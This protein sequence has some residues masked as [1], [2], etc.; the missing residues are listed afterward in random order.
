MRIVID[1]QA[2]QGPSRHRGIGRYAMALAQGLARNRGEHEI[3][4]ALNGLLADTIEPIRAALSGLV[5]ETNFLVWTAPGPVA[6]ADPLNDPRR[7]AAELVRE[8][9]LAS[10]SPD[11]VIVSS[12]FEGYGEDIVTSIGSLSSAVPTAAVLY[13]LIPLIHRQVY[14]ASPLIERWYENKLAHL[15]NADLLLAISES[16]RQEAL[17]WIDSDPGEV[18]N[19]STAAD[20]HFTPGE[21]SAEMRAHLAQT[22]GLDR[23]F[24][25]YTGG[26]DYRKN[27]EGLIA[28]FARLPAGVRKA[29]QLAIV[30]AVQDAE[31]T[32]LLKLAREAGLSNGDV[33]LTG[34]I[35]EDDLLA[36]YRGCELFVFPSWHEGFGLPALEAMKC[37]RA[38]IVADRAGLPEVVGLESA[39]F[40]PFDLDAMSAK[41]HAV[42]TDET[43]RRE[44]ERHGPTQAATFSWDTTA[45][46]AWAALETAHG[47]QANAARPAPPQRRPRLAFVSPVTPQASGISDYSAELLPELARHYQIDIVT[48]NGT[49]DNPWIRGNCGILDVEAFRRNAGGYDRVLYH[50]GNSEFHAHMFGLLRE[51]PGVVVLH[52]FF[53]SGIIAHLDKTGQRP[54]I[55]ARALSDSHGWAAVVE[56]YKAEDNDGVIWAYPCNLPVLQDALGIIVHAD[57]SSHLAREWYGDRAADDWRLIPHLRQPLPV[58]RAAARQALG[59]GADDFV[60]CSFGHIAPTKRSQMLLE[61]WLASPLARDPR[62]RLVFV[63]QNHGSRYCNAL[64]RQARSAATKGRVEITGWADIGKFRHWLQAADVA[65]Q[66][67]TLSRGE[68]SGTVL[69]CMNAGVATIVNA[70]GAM[71]ELPGDAVWM[72]EDECTVDELAAALEALYRQDQ[73]RAEL[74]QA[75]KAYVTR[76]HQP[77]R[78]ATAYGEAIEHYYARG[79]VGEQGLLRALTAH[80]PA[81]SLSEGDWAGLASAVA[82][83]LPRPPRPRR[84]LLDVTALADATA[85]AAWPDSKLGDIQILRRWLLNP[86]V[87][88]TVE[89]VRADPQRAGL[90]HA[91]R[92]A[93]ALLEIP[94]SWCEDDVVEVTAGDALLGHASG[95][96]LGLESRELQPLLRT[97]RQRGSGVHFIVRD[98]MRTASGTDVVAPE[99]CDALATCDG[100][101][102]ASRPMAEQVEAWLAGP[103]EETPTAPLAW[104]EPEGGHVHEH[105]KVVV[106]TGAG[107]VPERS[108]GSFEAVL[109]M[110]VATTNVR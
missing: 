71:A 92:F 101:I 100:I 88:W 98:A 105:G 57:Y 62:C 6:T 31:R 23:P 103:G 29:H 17:E 83:T 1:L 19:I 86:P 10:V 5:P 70:H 59:I 33:V 97:W 38:V 9:A 16:S 75:G 46:R 36:C 13:D 85:G 25:M 73:R 68:T 4:V 94:D 84:L 7:L 28:A 96:G 12:V 42:L 40:D 91:R 67:R 11:Y 109:E 87:G 102:C 65:V 63:G 79:A 22:Y 82:G 90:R 15:R 104:L 51:I 2:A 80:G 14:L 99:M 48:P 24:V 110:L 72:L 27:I 55:W 56:R 66:L 39:L 44:L 54:G 64:E 107:R 78:C 18:V 69:D 60:V 37:G 30:C 20:D 35:P 89:P 49:S 77:R 53:L 58:D 47:R 61:A 43:L 26:I 21:V 8:S 50:F 74:A 52:D 95:S 81:L 76:H 106:R 93:C 45:R 3:F 41:I 34:F 108:A 32:R